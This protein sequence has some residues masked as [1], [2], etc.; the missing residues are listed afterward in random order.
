MQRIVFEKYQGNGNDFIIIDSREIDY[1]KN[2]LLN[3]FNSNNLCD[4]NFGIGADG[5]IFILNAV[6]K[7]NDARMVIYNSD[8][9]EAEMCGNGIR[10]LIKFLKDTSLNN[11]PKCEYRIETKAGLKVSTYNQ[12]KIKVNMGKPF[13]ESHII[14]TSISEKIKNIPAKDFDINNFKST[15]YACS[16]GNP[17][18]VFFVDSLKKVNICELGPLFEKNEFFPKKTNVHFCKIINSKNIEVL[19]WE[20]GSGATLA[21]GTGACAIHSV[22]FR[23]GY[24]HNKSTIKLPGGIL[25]IEWNDKNDEVYMTGGAERVFSGQYN[26]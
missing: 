22:A 6:N 23:L 12:G 19:V 2:F 9:S 3:N 21:C 24:C 4:R 13:F 17:H 7:D 1:H 16:M 8:N 20:R 14:P 5:I 25:D 18:L 11:Y 10:C 15:G 26:Y